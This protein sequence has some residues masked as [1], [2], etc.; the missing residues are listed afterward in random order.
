METILKWLIAGYV[1]GVICMLYLIARSW[2]ITSAMLN[3]AG[4]A[5]CRRDLG[6]HWLGMAL[7]ST[8]ISLGWSFIGGG[9]HHWM[10]ND[11]RFVQFS[12]GLACAIAMLLLLGKTTHKVDK[13]A[14]N[15]IVIVGLGV[16]IPVMF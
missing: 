3:N 9:I 15:A 2:V 16:L 7:L 14:L 13:I 5:V 12:L 6:V 10:A 8:G 1:V 11:Q 4:K